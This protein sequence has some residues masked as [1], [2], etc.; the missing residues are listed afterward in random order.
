[1]ERKTAK[2]M[3]FLL[4]QALV[5]WL[6]SG[7]TA[8][9][10]QKDI[11]I[12]YTNDVHCAVDADIGYAGLA[13][14][15]KQIEQ[16]T[17][18][19]TLVDCGDALQGD[20]I[21]TV[22]RGEYL[23]DIMN[24]VGY[25]F[26]ILGNHEFDYGMEQLTA[27]MKR[28]DAQ[29]LGCN[30]AYSGSG[31]NALAEL[32]PYEIVT[33][34]DIKVAFLGVSTPESIAKSTPAYFMDDSGQLVYHFY[35]ESGDTLCAKV[36]ETVDECKEKGA[37]YVIA[38]THLGDDEGSAPFRSTDLIAGTSG[39]DAVL[40][41]HSHS[42]ISC[43]FIKNKD[44]KA[45]PLS[46]TGTGLVNIGQLVITPSGN[47]SAGLIGSYPEADPEMDAYIKTI[48]SQ[49]EADLNRVVARSETALSTAS[50]NGI[51]LIRSRET[52]LG[53]F[54]ADAYRAVAG[55]DIAIVN[56]GGIRA[57]LPEGDITYGDIIAV[58]PYGN[59]LCV[60]EVLGQEILDALEMASRSTLP[61]ISDG[62]NA[63]G[64]NGGF[65][66][67]SGLRYTIDTSVESTVQLDEAGMFVSCGDSRRI[68]DVQILRSDGSYE[69]LDPNQTYTLASH[70]YLIKQG[71]D[72][73][74]LFMDNSLI[75]DEGM[76]DYQV[77][78][79]YITENLGGTIGEDYAETENRITV[80]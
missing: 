37:D 59:T 35:G 66:Q 15:Q 70:N 48:Q 49:Y 77:L 34:G 19:V 80:R 8:Q 6:L 18:N 27:L 9:N 2:W 47:V 38:L 17:H 5:I 69:P 1:M 62:E 10:A 50:E 71:G 53:D 31:E 26:A 45:I 76:V 72:G 64:E 42:V 78:I 33:Y 79:T 23:V 21:G 68:K 44:G 56:G 63:V 74:N 30:I 73:L 65:L 3:R 22:S 32:K 13:A 61:E 41:G 36:Q 60:A 54:C 43:D 7:C 20:A 24:E 52:N 16:K 40:D 75:I 57:D 39:I 14:Y 51:R 46:S 4:L 55:A 29:Y 67:V 58:H 25:D 28:S 11:V 12:L